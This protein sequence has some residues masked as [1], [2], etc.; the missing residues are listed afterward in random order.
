MSTLSDLTAEIAAQLPT[1]VSHEITAAKLRLVLTDMVSRLSAQTGT[2]GGGAAAEYYLTSNTTANSGAIYYCSTAAGGFTVTLPD[3]PTP[4][5]GIGFRDAESSWSASNL[6]IFPGA[7][8]I[9]GASGNLVCDIT[10]GNFDLV[11]AGGNDGWELIPVSSFGSGGGGGLV[12]GA[13]TAYYHITANQPV[14]AG[15]IYY[16]DTTGGSFTITLPTGPAIGDGMSIRDASGTWGLSNLIVSPGSNPINS[17]VSSLV[18]DQS[19]INFDLVWRGT[20]TGWQIEIPVEDAIRSSTAFN[21]LR[22]AQTLGALGQA[23]TVGATGAGITWNPS[24]KATGI[25]LS[26]GNLTATATVS[27]G[28][29][30]RATV[31]GA[32]GRYFEVTWSNTGNSGIGL[33]TSAQSLTAYPGN[34]NSI[35][36][37]ASQYVEWPGSGTGNL[38][39]TGWGNGDVIGILLGATNCS[40]Y[41]NGTLIYTVNTLPSGPL[42]PILWLPASGNAGTANF[43]ATTMAF[44]PSGASSWNVGQT[45]SVTASWNPS[46]Q[47]GLVLTNSNLTATGTGTGGGQGRGTKSG[48]A[49]RYYEA[50]ID[51]SV[52]SGS[53]Y[54]GLAN[55]SQSIFGGF[56]QDP[57]GIG[58]FNN[59]FVARPGGTNNWTPYVTGDII[60]VRLLS[61]TAEFYRNGALQGTVGIPSGTI[62]PIVGCYDTNSIVTANFGATTFSALPSGATAWGAP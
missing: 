43:G 59:G 53:V 38:T 55:T 48:T 4:G 5:T 44:L 9:E 46:D 25:T 40:L 20:P 50:H 24:D 29:G 16:T 51:S 26:A 45:S 1:G 17:N 8:K 42:Y 14:A 27:T 61:G 36:F 23:F 47:S 2:S 18:I 52:R 49:G 31:P 41:K 62:Y 35:G 34:P 21:R 33:S 3:T 39:G 54:V 7:N 56:A 12:A 57:D 19:D 58:Y 6:T 37:F 60:G 22:A 11:W 28:V 15:G 10:N 30:V 32:A 13:G